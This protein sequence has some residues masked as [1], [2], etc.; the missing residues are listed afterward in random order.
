MAAD[1]QPPP[2]PGPGSQAVLRPVALGPAFQV[3]SQRLGGPR[4]IF[5]MEQLPPGGVGELQLTGRVAEHRDQAV[6]VHHPPRGGIPVPRAQVR[7][8]HRQPETF[9]GSFGLAV[10][11]LG[12][13]QRHAL[14][15]A[16]DERVGPVQ[17]RPLRQ[18]MLLA[19]PDQG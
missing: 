3:L 19:G 17:R 10:G 11:G 1:Q 12:L 8:F 7:P 18:P 15:P 6:I 9:A 14:A 4:R 13:V 16:L 2:L 5:G